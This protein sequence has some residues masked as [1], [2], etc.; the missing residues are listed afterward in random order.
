MLSGLGG[1]VG[2]AA[3]VPRY[4]TLSAFISAVSLQARA[5]RPDGFVGD[6]G[7][8]ARVEGRERIFF[9]PSDEMAVG[10]KGADG[11]GFM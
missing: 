10:E 11:D 9:H 6:S 2:E 1:F 5:S 3:K 4:F 8:R 7:G